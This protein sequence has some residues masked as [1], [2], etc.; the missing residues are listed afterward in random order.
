MKTI[1]LNRTG[2]AIFGDIDENFNE[3]K[4]GFALSLKQYNADWNFI[5]FIVTTDTPV[6][7]TINNVWQPKANG[8]YTNFGA[9]VVSDFTNQVIIKTSTGYSVETIKNDKASKFLAPCRL[10]GVIK[11]L[12]IDTSNAQVSFTGL[13]LRNI[14]RNHTFDGGNTYYWQIAIV[15]EDDSVV[16]NVNT[17]VNPEGN[18]YATIAPYNSSGITAYAIV[19]W[20]G[21]ASGTEIKD[22]D[23]IRKPA[24][25]LNFSPKLTELLN[26]L[27]GRVDDVDN[28]RL[29]YGV[30]TGTID[31]AFSARTITI[32]QIR[33]FYESGKN[34]KYTSAEVVLTVA[35]GI[36]NGLIGFN[37]TDST[38]QFFGSTS[39]TNPPTL[40]AGYY[41]LG[42]VNFGNGT[43]FLFANKYSINGVNADSRLTALES[44]VTPETN[45]DAKLNFPTVIYRLSQNDD[46][47][48]IIPK[49]YAESI[50]SD[51]VD[52]NINK[53]REVYIDVN[54]SIE[55][56]GIGYKKKSATVQVRN[57]PVSNIDGKTAKVLCIGSSTTEKGHAV[58]VQKLLDMLEIDGIDTSSIELIGTRT[59]TTPSYTYNGVT[60]TSTAKHEGQSGWGVTSVLRHVTNVR[61]NWWGNE[62]SSYIGNMYGQVAWDSLGLGTLGG[63]QAYEA[64][65]DSAAQRE[66]MMTTCHGVYDA[67]PTSVLWTY[68]VGIYPSGF[69]YN[70]VSYTWG[71]S[72]DS[73]ED[74]KIILAVKYFCDNPYNKFYN[75]AS[76]VASAGEYAFSISTY[77]ANNALATPTHL[78][79]LMG[80]NDEALL[81]ESEGGIAYTSAAVDKIVEICK[82][83]YSGAS[84]AV[85][86][87]RRLGV[88]TTAKW[89]DIGVPYFYNTSQS[90]T[91]HWALNKALQA[92]YDNSSDADFLATFATEAVLP[93][94]TR[95]IYDPISNE[96]KDYYLDCDGIHL[97][98]DAWMS[99]SYQILGW[100]AYTIV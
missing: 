29:C 66:L 30:T 26:N 11:E 95:K 48:N 98:G 71:E 49:L 73:G 35:T 12:W 46:T 69:T 82:T 44:A 28:R 63:S 99:I 100:L 55:I 56:S 57:Y 33:I 20:D 52:I 10:N 86:L 32:P 59:T 37:P 96:E 3:T 91:W 70:S 17:P 85:G 8:T 47:F 16:C 77:I 78:V 90:R 54:R 65:T 75:K 87:Y 25:D 51:A 31:I 19:D 43:A 9:A 88:F 62:A 34:S 61:G 89:S 81:Q 41:S 67:D 60:Q 14:R 94:P 64:Y 4:Q 15:K 7:T 2:T 18:S 92:T 93:T 50:C 13:R 38:F 21:I 45:I 5:D 68:L 79:L 80:G 39:D 23:E 42:L 76:V 53:G 24:F 36:Y 84:I 22:W 40:S 83:T 6:S 74:A 27:P 72:Y 58:Y 97:N 1:D